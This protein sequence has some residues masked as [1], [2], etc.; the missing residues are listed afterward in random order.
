MSLR[1][2]GWPFCVTAHRPIQKSHCRDSALVHGDLGGTHPTLS[3]PPPLITPRATPVGPSV[4][5]LS[6]SRQWSTAKRR[7]L[8]SYVNTLWPTGG[9]TKTLRP[10]LSKA[11]GARPTTARHPWCNPAGPRP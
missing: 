8:R 1:P 10:T 7:S 5:A 3:N 4:V 2:A 11:H 9:Q 6:T